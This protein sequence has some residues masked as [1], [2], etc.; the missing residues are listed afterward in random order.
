MRFGYLIKR[1]FEGIFK[2]WRANI[3]LVICLASSFTVLATFLLIT[4]NLQGMS[5]KLKG[6]VQ[7][8]VYLNDRITPEQT[9]S[10]Q[11]K[12][13]SFPEVE[14]AVYRSKEEAVTQLEDYLGK[15]TLSGLDSNTLPA[16]FQVSVKIEHR[17]FQPI[18][19]LASKIQ[20]QE[21]V[22][23]VE[24]GGEWL[25]KLDK[26]LRV[27]YAADLIFGILVALSVVLI[28]SNFM[29]VEVLSQSESIQ[30]MSLLGASWKDIYLPLLLQGAILG[31]LGAGLGL[32]L[33]WTGYTIFSAKLVN[34]VF[35]PFHM[36]A[37]LII[38]GIILGG[39]GSLW[40]TK[41]P[42]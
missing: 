39:G 13:Q 11:V 19:L 40:S 28:V 31:G 36:M 5:Q 14:T 21:G 20:N 42:A 17:K 23:G 3:I 1:V 25:S 8:E 4:I 15:E 38:W 7:I 41:K 18:S 29:R 12:I 10:L 37:G 34:L 26:A 6:K 35:L 32:V 30:V 16:S 24:F 2:R 33:V 27:F 9:R 22:E